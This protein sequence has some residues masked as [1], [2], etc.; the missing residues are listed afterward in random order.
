MI[1]ISIN[2]DWTWNSCRRLD[3]VADAATGLRIS[4]EDNGGHL[5]ADRLS[6]LRRAIVDLEAVEKTVLDRIAAETPITRKAA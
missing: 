4:V 5:W 3:Q 1:D 2:H 6:Q